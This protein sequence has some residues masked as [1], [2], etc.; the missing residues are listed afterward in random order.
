MKSLFIFVLL[1]I[2][3]NIST[4]YAKQ[5]SWNIEI[6]TGDAYCV[7]SPLTISQAGYEDIYVAA[8][9]N[10]HSFEQPIYYSICISKWK[11]NRAW[12]IELIHLKIELSNKVSEIQRFEISHGFNLLILNHCWKLDD[13]IFRLGSGIVIPHPENTIRGKQLSEKKGIFNKG[14]YVS[15]PAVQVGGSKRV[16]LSHNFFLSAEGKLTFAYS[17]IPINDGN[18]A[19]YNIAVHFLFGFG[20][21]L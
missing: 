10:T 15:G 18:A 16:A 4:S 3:S 20:F 11:T 19:V 7:K 9:Y 8:K 12:E 6:S 1:L 21:K 2:A 14:Y 17:K 13:T 5:Y